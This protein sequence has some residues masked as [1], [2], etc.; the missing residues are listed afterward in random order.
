MKSNVARVALQGAAFTFD[1]LYTYVLPPDLLGTAMAGSRVLVPFGRGNI[2][3]QG[4]IME[5]SEDEVKGLKS[6]FS[7]IDA[8]PILNEEMLAVCKYLHD[9]TFCTY[10][11]AVHAILPTGLTHRLV[12]YYSAN[13]E[14][15]DTS[16]LN[17]DERDIFLYLS[18]N[19]EKS[20]GDIKKIFGV[21]PELLEKMVEKQA[22]LKNCDTKQK[23]KDATQK[24]VRISPEADLAMKFTQ[25][26][27]EVLNILQDVGAAAVKEICYFTGVT[28][29]VIDGLV[30]KNVLISFEKQVYRSPVN[31]VAVKPTEIKL[32]D[33]QQ[34]AFDGLFSEYNRKKGA[35]SLLYGVTGS[36]KTQVFLR[37]VD[38]AV[39]ENK[40]V[41]VMVP[42]ISLTPQLLS[43]FS[44]RYG[45]KIAVFHSAMSLGQRMD[46][47]K[48]INDGEALI[49]LG[50][51]SAVFAPFKNLGLVIM[52]E[53]QEHTYKSEQSPRFHARDVATFRVKRNGGLL[54]LA[55]ATPSVKTFTLARLGKIS[56]YTLKNRYGNAVLPQVETVDTLEE[57]KSGNKGILSRRLYSAMDEALEKGEQIILLLNRRGHNTY[58]SCPECGSV[59]SCPNCSISL[60]Y[61]SANNRLM[62]HYCGYSVKAEGKCSECGGEHVKFSGAGT[63]KA[64]EELETLFPNAKVLRLDADSTMTRDSYSTKLN[65]FASGEYDILLGTQMVAKGLD[66]PN[67]TLVGVLGADNSMYSDDYRSFERTFSLLTQ[68]IGRAGRGEA[69]GRAII[70]TSNPD[71][72]LIEL[73]QNQDYDSFYEEEIIS[74]KLMIYPPYCEICVVSSKSADRANAEKAINAVSEKIKEL[75]SDEFSNVKLTILG[76]APAAVPKVNNKYRYRMIIK[77]KNTKEFRDMLR[78]A[79]DVKLFGD[80]ALSV[81]FNPETII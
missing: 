81:D 8:T 44:A 77:C 31:K 50:T 15:A 39:K 16:L 56:L 68:V 45:D 51:R 78:C 43:I 36:G 55:S 69:P 48:R 9:R 23:C 2:K 17:S 18:N 5:I 33:E 70:Q 73:A 32:T 41:I 74:R 46:E 42:E 49:A 65:K 28:A 59:A 12:N 62:C 1:K 26:Q 64:Q 60:T 76:P 3:R 10:Y 11:D 52:D 21:M 71:S 40:G 34:R 20:D 25:R 27:T 19:S 53:E 79:L 6:I 66:F 22:L 37:L 80:S 67:V 4:I 63:Q 35:V 29:S 54:V 72:N 30:K 47:W 61:H 75:L 38:E 24:W 13:P 14:F 57:L 7:L 58:I